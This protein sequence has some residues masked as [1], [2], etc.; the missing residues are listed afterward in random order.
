[1][2]MR[3]P[4]VKME[5]DEVLQKDVARIEAIW[6]ECIA[7]SGGPFLF[8]DFC[9]ADAMYAPVVN[10]L[11]VYKLSENKDVLAYM[12]NMKSLSAWQ[13]WEKAGKA[14]PWIV[15]EDEA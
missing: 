3:R 2:D 6:T 13:E 12:E 8:G 10:R 7:K 5:Q 15:E 1:M 14:E 9:I 4:I 11:E